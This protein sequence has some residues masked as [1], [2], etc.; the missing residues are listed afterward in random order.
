MGFVA[1]SL[2]VLPEDTPHRQC[3]RGL[4][5]VLLWKGATTAGF[6]LL[7]SPWPCW[8]GAGMDT[9]WILDSGLG[10][11][12]QGHWVKS[13]PVTISRD[14]CCNNHSHNTNNFITAINT[15]HL[16]STLC[17]KIVAHTW[18]SSEICFISDD[19][20]SLKGEQIQVYTF[21]F[22]HHQIMGA[23]TALA[24]GGCILL[25]LNRGPFLAFSVWFS[26]S[27]HH[28]L[29]WAA[30]ELFSTPSSLIPFSVWVWCPLGTPS[31]SSMRSCWLVSLLDCFLC[32]CHCGLCGDRD[33]PGSSPGLKHLAYF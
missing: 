24:H 17:W 22:K 27:K 21:L 2:E 15:Q 11:L 30:P 8:V 13:S 7:G 29:Q 4:R 3:R 12:G 10:G 18:F 31:S 5:R 9:P 6:C 1:F 16:H 25:V 23:F 14:G 33:M 26:S 32:L 19:E 20:C 28:F